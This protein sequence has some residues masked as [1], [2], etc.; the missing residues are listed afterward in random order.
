[1]TDTREAWEARLRGGPHRRPPGQ[2]PN[3]SFGERQVWDT[4]HGEYASF[5]EQQR[6][7]QRLEEQEEASEKEGSDKGEG[8]ESEEESEE[9]SKEE[10]EEGSEEE[11]EQHAPARS[12]GK[13]DGKGGGKD[14]K[15]PTLSCGVCGDTLQNDDPGVHCQNVH[16][17]CSECSANFVRGALEEGV[18]AIPPKCPFCA[19]DVNL[20]SFERQL[21]TEQ[22][23]TYMSYMVMG[24]LPEG[25]TMVHCPFGSCPYF[26]IRQLG[27]GSSRA[28][29]NF[30]HCQHPACMKVS[31]G[32]CKKECVPCGDEDED[33][34]D[35]DGINQKQRAMTKHFIC[36]E[37]QQMFGEQRKVFEKA[38]EASTQFACPKCGLTGMKDGECTHMTCIGCQTVWCYVCGLDTAS[39]ECSKANRSDQ[40]PEYA[41]NVNWHS[42]PGRCPMYLSE[43]NQVDATYPEEDEAALHVLHRQKALRLLRCAYIPSDPDSF[44]ISRFPHNLSLILSTAS[45]RTEYDKIGRA[46]Y[47]C[48]IAA[49]PHLGAACG[50]SEEDILSVEA[51]QP[52]FQRSEDFDEEAEDDEDDD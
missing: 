11:E 18:N 20:P 29:I 23:G 44:P 43:I 7:R 8:E 42:R 31:C 47:R 21:T 13:T 14:G 22:H 24:Q 12:G 45:R 52:L 33:E 38:I 28:Q 26:E 50:F 34:D 1:M 5:L 4:Y 3:D 25:E 9:G 30:F 6:R 46:Q 37:N 40:S 17:M 41:H 32:L 2:A 19:V 10:S 16:H 35:D 36:A 48:L 49:F 27:E 51:H 39:D 15:G